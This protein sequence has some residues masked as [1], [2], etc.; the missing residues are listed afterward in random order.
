MFTLGFNNNIHVSVSRLSALTKRRGR[1]IES[2]VQFNDRSLSKRLSG[3]RRGS[4]IMLP[5]PPRR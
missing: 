1:L 2:G 3:V 5:R 4:V